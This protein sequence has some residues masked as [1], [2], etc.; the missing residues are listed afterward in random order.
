MVETATWSFS[1][2]LFAFEDISPMNS[3]CK[4]D[5]SENTASKVNDLSSVLEL[6]SSL[7]T[8]AMALSNAG[9][10]TSRSAC[11]SAAILSHF[12][13]SFAFFSLSASTTFFCSQPQ[14]KLCFD[15]GLLHTVAGTRR[16]HQV[17]LHQ[18]AYLRSRLSHFPSSS[19]QPTESQRL[20]VA[21]QMPRSCRAKRACR[22]H[23]AQ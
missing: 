14:T 7:S 1:R 2:S 17:S 16:D 3:A 15:R 11:A 4:C 9:K 8:S 23:P 5:P 13:A 20:S 22:F 10:A 18:S 19:M 21:L 6:F 12:A